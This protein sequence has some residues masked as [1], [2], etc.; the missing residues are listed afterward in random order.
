MKKQLPKDNK[1]YEIVYDHKN[2]NEVSRIRTSIPSIVL[3]GDDNEEGRLTKVK[4]VK[5]FKLVDYSELDD[6]VFNTI[7][8]LETL[9]IAL[10]SGQMSFI[11]EYLKGECT[12][13][14]FSNSYYQQA[15]S[16]D[17]ARG[18]L[19]DLY[20]RLCDQFEYTMISFDNSGKDIKQ[21]S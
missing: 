1:L 9:K 12:D 10:G 13:E 15:S 18:I 3:Q 19:N 7:Q 2:G 17:L 5:N 14:D 6:K 16:L 21:A 11:D 20:D 4:E 8:L